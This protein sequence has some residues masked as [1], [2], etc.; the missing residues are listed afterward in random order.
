MN[1]NSDNTTKKDELPV[2]PEQENIE[3]MQDIIFTTI[4]IFGTFGNLFVLFII[5]KSKGRLRTALSTIFIINQSLLD[6]TA[7]ILLFADHWTSRLV[8][9][10]KLTGTF[11][12]WYCRAW[13]KGAWVWGI[14]TGSS[15][16]LVLLSLERYFSV[17]FPIAHK[18]LSRRKII[19]AAILVWL[20]FISYEFSH[21]TPTSTISETG[22][23]A[24]FSKWPN[25]LIRR[26]VG[27]LIIAIQFIIPLIII[28]F[29]YISLAITFSK[30]SASVAPSQHGQDMS[31]RVRKN[32]IKTFAIVACAFDTII[33]SPYGEFKK[34]LR[35]YRLFKLC[36]RSK[37][38]TKEGANMSTDKTSTNY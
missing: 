6:M 5:L 35:K 36:M 15:Y 4:S 20:I 16:N 13:Y 8:D 34:E 14:L 26:S 33:I 11:L 27:V 38:E 12:I 22:H 1:S 24:P 23:C 25:D 9:E 17:I 29:S 19:I 7:A 32:S 18:N 28:A 10:T 31:Q 3:L 30:K 37:G 2:D 21:Q